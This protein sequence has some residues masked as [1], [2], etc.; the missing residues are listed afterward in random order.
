MTEMSDSLWEICC[1]FADDPSVTAQELVGTL[2]ARHR[3]AQLPAGRNLGLAVVRG[4]IRVGQ[5]SSG[6]GTGP[7]AFGG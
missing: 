4:R 7:C 6:W 1:V 2:A 5:T 3:R